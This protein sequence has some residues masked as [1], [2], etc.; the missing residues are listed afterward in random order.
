MKETRKIQVSSMRALAIKE[1][2]FTKASN[3][4]YEA[5]FR[6]SY[7]DNLKTSTIV[8]MAKTVLHYSD[9]YMTIAD[10]CF[11]IAEV[12]Y[13]FFQNETVKESLMRKIESRK[14][15]NE[16]IENENKKAAICK[17]VKQVLLT[18]DNVKI[19]IE[20]V[21]SIFNLCIKGQVIEL[22]NP[23]EETVKTVYLNCV[24]DGLDVLLEMNK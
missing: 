15:E 19:N 16:E 21:E 23:H 12:S 4:E 7:C 11:L 9:T 22:T 8:E 2:W 3:E 24:V 5:W 18:T 6:L 10:I 20:V 17:E 1:N 14:I 13:T